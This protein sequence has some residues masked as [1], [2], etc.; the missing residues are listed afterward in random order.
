MKV[1]Y[2]SRDYSPHD[3][4]FLTA[5]AQT[6]HKIFYLRLEQRVHSLEDRPIPQIVEQV[7]WEGG[8]QPAQLQHGV[9]LL[10]SLRQ[11]L[12]QV[13]PDIVHAGPIQ[14]AA[15]LV[16][17]SGFRHLVSMSWGYDLLVDVHRSRVWRWATRFT[18]QHSAAF[19]GDC[20]II[21]Q[22]AASLGMKPEKIFSFPWGVDLA[23]FC[24]VPVARPENSLFTLL[25][26]RSWEP[27]YGVDV[28][29]QAFAWVARKRPG[30]R[31]VMAGNGSLA[32]RLRHIFEQAGVSER[33]YFP[34]HIVQA[35]LRR[36]YRA[37]NLYLSASHSD[38]SS[39]SL[40]EAMACGCPALVS[41][42]PGNRE[43]VTDGLNGWLFR[44]GSVQD[45]AEKI[46]VAIESYSSLSAIGQAARA[47]VETRA[48]WSKNFPKLLQAYEM[49]YY[50]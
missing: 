20:E 22:Q 28:L 5:L 43:W 45:L 12:H 14:T 50:S 4:R 27:I 19:V 23:Y 29:A 21:N 16:A 25:S 17:L 31:L 36:Y 49:A 47:L 48:D 11:V 38:G 1:I 2:F 15:F 13:N 24:P 34:G 10:H 41:D 26:T 30:I 39:I 35:D 42:I 9:R 40:L 6:E 7:T 3:H 37:A 8:R 32:A 18:L 46:E 44:D 33:V